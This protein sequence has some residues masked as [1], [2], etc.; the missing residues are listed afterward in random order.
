MKQVYFILIILF[1]LTSCVHS[2]TKILNYISQ[3]V[4]QDISS[5]IP[6]LGYPDGGSSFKDKKYIF[7]QKMICNIFPIIN[8]HLMEL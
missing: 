6:I 2:T 8:I 3:Y 5:I 7:G 1:L 4:G